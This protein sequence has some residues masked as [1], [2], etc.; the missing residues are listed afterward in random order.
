ML[1][2][3]IG[4]PKVIR[5]VFYLKP[6]EKNLRVQFCKFMKENGIGP[7]DIFLLMKVYF[8]YLHI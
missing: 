1:N 5:K 4:K 8:L 6:N 7:E 3:F 2:K